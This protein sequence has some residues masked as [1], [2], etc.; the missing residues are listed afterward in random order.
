MLNKISV[1]PMLYVSQLGVMIPGTGGWTFGSDDFTMAMKEPAN[2]ALNSGLLRG[3]VLI[4][5]KGKVIMSEK[6]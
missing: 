2:E 6:T 4:N 1:L 5:H 3:V